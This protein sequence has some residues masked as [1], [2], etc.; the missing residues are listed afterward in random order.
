MKLNLSGKNR[1][2]GV[3]PEIGVYKVWCPDYDLLDIS[4]DTGELVRPLGMDRK[5]IV[6]GAIIVAL[7]LIAG[8]N[9]L[10][11]LSNRASD[12]G[13]SIL[14]LPFDNFTGSDSLEFVVAGMHSSLIGDLGRISG[15]RVISPH[16][17]KAYKNSGKTLSEIAEELN[18]DVIL[19]ASV[20]CIGDS[21]CFQP[22]L[23]SA[24]EEEKQLWIQN[25][26]NEKS[27]VLNL[28]NQITKKISEEINIVL[29]P[30]EEKLIAEER[31]VNPE[32]FD[33]YMRGQFNLD[34]I[35]FFLFTKS[36][37]IFQTSH[38]KGSRMGCSS[39]RSS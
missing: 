6:I 1:L 15:L 36:S 34:Q 27:Q 8:L 10:P 31:T 20:M 9:F 16:T 39:C 13:K 5:S 30:E 25:Y 28:Y 7:L 22:K 18:V 26:T 19:D 24:E 11:Q 14:V 33:L 2:K 32:A 37:R 12:F 4:V 23:M 17:S 38:R 3:H 35:N 29:T 21:I